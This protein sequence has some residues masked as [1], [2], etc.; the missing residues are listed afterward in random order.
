MKVGKDTIIQEAWTKQLNTETD[1]AGIPTRL[2]AE[3]RWGDHD[4]EIRIGLAV[5]EKLRSNSL[6]NALDSGS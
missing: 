1:G 6:V 5:R 3:L 4:L 2:P